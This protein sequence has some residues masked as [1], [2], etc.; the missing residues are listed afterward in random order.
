MFTLGILC[1]QETEKRSPEGDSQDDEREKDGISNNLSEN[2]YNEEDILVACIN[3]AMPNNTRHGKHKHNN[4]KL[5]SKINVLGNS[6]SH[7]RTSS[8]PVKASNL[9]A[10]FSNS[11][12]HLSTKSTL[13]CSASAAVIPCKT[14]NQ[15]SDTY[16]NVQHKENVDNYSCKNSDTHSGPDSNSDT[17]SV[18]DDDNDKIL[19][20]CIQSGM[21]KASHSTGNSNSYKHVGTVL[22]PKIE[23]SDKQKFKNHYCHVFSDECASKSNK[24]GKPQKLSKKQPFASCHMD[25][26]TTFKLEG[27]P[28]NFSTNTSSLSDLTFESNYEDSGNK[29]ISHSHAHV[30][31]ASANHHL[32]A[33]DKSDFAS[34]MD[35]NLKSNYPSSDSKLTKSSCDGEVNIKKNN[36]KFFRLF[37]LHYY[38]LFFLTLSYDEG[39]G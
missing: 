9:R 1:F 31:M 10:G 33:E 16:K 26:M 3:S 36:G 20:Q 22:E 37:L 38:Y 2:D 6:T 15:Q 34:S 12:V 19:A 7:M 39:V 25:S 11:S 13:A 28:L 5:Y 27:T 8:I 23:N 14:V 17:S 32:K 21:P 35:K 29:S 18:F 24:S 4:T 30:A